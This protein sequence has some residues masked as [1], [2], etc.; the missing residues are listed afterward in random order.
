MSV[1]DGVDW[2]ARRAG[3]Y[4]GLHQEPGGLGL[5]VGYL[6]L[7]GVGIVVYP[8]LSDV[9]KMV[10]FLLLS[11]ATVPAVMIGLNRTPA[12]HRKPFWFLLAALVSFNA[13]NVAWYWYVFAM[14]L[15]SGDGGVVGLFAALGQVFMFAGAITI[16]V[17]RGRDDVG[18]LIDA[19]IV[20]MVAGGVL[21]NFLLLPHLRDVGAPAI[22]QVSTCVMVFMLT[23]IFGCLV[24]LL[25]TAREFIPAL[26]FL[27]AAMGSS[28][29]G[30]VSVALVV[31]P[32][33]SDRPAYTD[34]AY[35]AGYT[36]VGL[37]ALARSVVRLLQPGP[38]PTDELSKERLLFL[39]LALCAMPAVGSASELLGRNVDTTL[40]AV[41]TAAV[42]PLV[43]LRIWSVWSE[44]VRV[45]RYQASVDPV[46]NLPNRAEFL[47]RLD[48]A[49]AAGRP[50]VVLFC[51]LDGFKNVNDR[52]G[53]AGGDQVLVD[54]AGRLRGCVRPGD[55]VSRFGGDEFVILCV[56]AQRD[57][58]TELCRRIER[59][60]R[61][62]FIV[63][64]EPVR[65]G[66]S[67]G[68]AWND[69]PEDGERL[70]RRAD[71]AMYTA[72]QDRRAGPGLQICLATSERV[73]PGS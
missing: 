47:R 43:M 2:T 8:Y 7:C 4:R 11:F 50:V 62:P 21:W 65:L 17:R 29:V 48:A 49:L 42:T 5:S 51:D 9:Q 22:S 23:G 69:R 3:R 64:G 40:L 54:M 33:S 70:I 72:K 6:V 1:F 52:Y 58:A 73:T 63:A 45:L 14:R 27:L 46:T 61:P 41:N 13:S 16:V 20:S 30:V 34:M 15:P 32:G 53:H 38:A 36:A 55:T 12:G 35:L 66:A 25:L 37:T 68:V 60:F 31:V 71:T 67:I 10:D 59:V 26:W 19:T 57:D 18:G 28:L 56:D 39:G 44:R 24:R